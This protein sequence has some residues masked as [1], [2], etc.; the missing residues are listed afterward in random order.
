MGTYYSPTGISGIVSVTDFAFL[1]TSIDDERRMVNLRKL[2]RRAVPAYC[3]QDRSRPIPRSP[4]DRLR[5]AFP[6]GHFDRL[7]ELT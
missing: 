2:T 5:I 7:T 1:P 4:I 3:A 6:S